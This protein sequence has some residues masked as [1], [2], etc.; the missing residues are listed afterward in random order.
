[1][2]TPK[3]NV[4]KELFEKIKVAA[5]I[6]GCTSPEEFAQQILLARCEEI[7]AATGN[8]KAKLSKEEEQQLVSQLNGLGYLE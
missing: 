2:F 4:S 7:I 8:N 5:Q 6:S 3:I 1:M